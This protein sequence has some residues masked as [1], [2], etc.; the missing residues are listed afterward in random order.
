MLKHL[1]SNNNTILEKSFLSMVSTLL[2]AL[3][4]VLEGALYH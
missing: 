2:T 3:F 1:V 4:K